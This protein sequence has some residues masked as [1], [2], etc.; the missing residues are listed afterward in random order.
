M[1]GT[2]EFVNNKYD[3]NV[4]QNLHDDSCKKSHLDFRQGFALAEVATSRS[5]TLTFAVHLVIPTTSST[6]SSTSHS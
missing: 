5:N 3:V 6:L 4:H 1:L 2:G